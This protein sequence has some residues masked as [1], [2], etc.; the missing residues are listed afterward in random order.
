MCLDFQNFDEL[1]GRLKMRKN[2]ILIITASVLVFILVACATTGTVAKTGKASDGF[3]FVEGG[4]FQMGDNDDEYA[5]AKPV[6]T[7]T[8]NSFYIC[9]HEVTQKEYRDIT[10]NN[11]NY[12]E[13][14]NRPVDSVSWY[15]AVEYCNALSIKKG[16]TPCYTIDKTKKDFN[17]K[18]NNA[19]DPDKWIVACDFSANG[20]R[21][22][23][24]AEW[25][26][27]ARGGKKSKGYKYSGSNNIEDVAW[28]KGNSKGESH[29]VKTKS[30]NEL[31]LYDMSGNVC[32]W[33]WDWDAAYSPSIQTNPTGASSSSSRSQRGSSWAGVDILCSVVWRGS[34]IPASG[35]YLLKY[36]NVGFRVVRSAQ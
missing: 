11:S 25:E 14:N 5:Y 6:H 12:F 9:D 35:L 7:V 29:D 13:G 4:T 27:A 26:Y 3:V 32:E 33:C 8:V 18:A 28:Y 34:N 10:R 23:T 19:N 21:L 1:M 24:E 31:G 15:D 30:P 16:F 20:Y 22:P 36:G 17:N 2:V